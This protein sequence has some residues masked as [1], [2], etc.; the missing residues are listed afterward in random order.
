MQFKG[1]EEYFRHYMSEIE[2]VPN[3]WTNWP[4]DTLAQAE[5]RI[6]ILKATETLWRMMATNIHSAVCVALACNEYSEKEFESI[7]LILNAYLS[8][9]QNVFMTAQI[10]ADDVSQLDSDSEKDDEMHET[11]LEMFDDCFDPMILKIRHINAPNN[12]EEEV[13]PTRIFSTDHLQKLQMMMKSLTR[14]SVEDSEEDS[15]EDSVEDSE[16]DSVEDSE[17]DSEE[18]YSECV[19]LILVQELALILSGLILADFLG[20]L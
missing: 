17:E 8:Q 15:G 19:T 12:K 6:K 20:Y 5:L 3:Y 11:I 1:P 13:V 7:K 10:D 2:R 16:E 18:Q 9:M 14:S 4:D